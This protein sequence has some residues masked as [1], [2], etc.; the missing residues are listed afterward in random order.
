MLIVRATRDTTPGLDET[1]VAF[2]AAARERL[3][4]TVIEHPGPHAFDLREDTP[5]SCAVIEQV[6]EFLRQR[7]QLACRLENV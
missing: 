2:L 3:A 7:L 6:V 1:L 4:L 5:E